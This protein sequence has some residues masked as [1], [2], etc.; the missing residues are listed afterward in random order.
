MTSGNGAQPDRR[1]WREACGCWPP[2][3]SR[4][5]PVFM[6][7]CGSPAGRLGREAWRDLRA[8]F[9][10]AL[11]REL[12]AEALHLYMHGAAVVRRAAQFAAGLR[13]QVGQ[14]GEWSRFCHGNWM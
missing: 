1:K 9:L 14:R 13:A 2:A 10:A 11:Q 12:P 4:P 5:C 8:A 7:V 3:A 6:A